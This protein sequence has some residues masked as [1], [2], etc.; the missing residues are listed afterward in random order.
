VLKFAAS[1]TNFKSFVHV[2]TTYCHP[3][4]TF[5]DEKVGKTV[6]IPL[7]MINEKAILLT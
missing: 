6:E 5:I 4:R 3:D 2:S 7:K 1:L